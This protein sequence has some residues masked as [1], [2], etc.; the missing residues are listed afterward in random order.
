[1]RHRL[2]LH[3]KAAGD[4]RSTVSVER[5]VFKRERI[6]FVDTDAPLTVTDR[7]VER[8]VLGAIKKSL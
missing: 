8:D 3:I 4:A 1:M 2:R 6:L 5:S 7:Q